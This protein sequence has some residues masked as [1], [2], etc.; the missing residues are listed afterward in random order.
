MS[1]S[2]KRRVEISAGSLALVE[3]GEPDDPAVVLLHGIGTSSFLWRNVAPLFSPWMH[4]V[5]PD[6][7]ATGDS[8]AAADAELGLRGQS[9]AVRELLDALGVESCAVV[10]HGLGGGIAQLLAFEGRARSMILVDS[11]A[12][13]A[14][15]EEPMRRAATDSDAVATL[16]AWFDLG[17]GH[18]A[19]LS[20]SELDEYLRPYRGDDGAKLSRLL[21]AADTASALSA[22]HAK[23]SALEI[24]VLVLWGEDDPFCSAELAER[25]ADALPRSSAALVPGCSHFLPEDAPETIAPLMF[26]YLRSM[27]LGVHHD[28]GGGGGPVPI[29]L[30]RRSTDVGDRR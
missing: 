27:Y 16:R 3:M 9:D 11:V 19:R 5:A 15:P 26:E 25:L 17:M 18:R 12:L 30:G 4:V 24:P 29:E 14:R 23:L 6:L 10:G 8:R 2:E 28:H 1:W 21:A 20:E 13:D 22:T 7:L